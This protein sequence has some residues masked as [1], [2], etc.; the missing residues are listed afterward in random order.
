M[1]RISDEASLRA[2]YGQPGERS[3]KKQLDRLDVHCRNFIALS[4]FV[5]L[6][7]T[8]GDG[9]P[10]ITPRGDA[11][12][13]IAVLDDKT[14]LLPDRL[15]NNRLDNLANVFANP[16]VGLL[17]LVPGIDETLRVHGT[18]EIR[19]DAELLARCVADGKP[20]KTVLVVTVVEAYYQCA[21]ALM[22]SHLWDP[23]TRIDRASF[24]SLGQILKDQIAGNTLC[25]T[26]EEMVERYRET[27]Y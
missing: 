12:G 14:L 1:A 13:F 27:L 16:G 3:L 2:L 21:K 9:L 24:P 8:G 5:V 25:E 10:D 4:P 6:S 26:Q 11:P 17:F 22:R 7:T 23:A 20:P 19:D 18:A 15:G